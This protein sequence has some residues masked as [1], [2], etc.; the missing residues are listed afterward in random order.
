MEFPVRCITCQKVIGNKHETY[1]D[2]LA[3]P[4]VKVKEWAAVN[5]TRSKAFEKHVVSKRKNKDKSRLTNFEVLNMLKVKRYC[6]RQFFLTYVEIPL[7]D[8]DYLEKTFSRVKFLNKRSD[9]TEMP[10]KRKRD[11][12]SVEDLKRRP[13]EDFILAR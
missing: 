3:S 5:S 6:C 2:L 12:T 11:E 1:T 4:Y 9:Y 7:P 13:K 10:Q 8:P